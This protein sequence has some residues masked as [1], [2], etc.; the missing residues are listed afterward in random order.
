GG[1]H[2]HENRWYYLEN[3][4]ANLDSQAL[5]HPGPLPW[6]GSNTAPLGL[7][8]VTLSLF[9]VGIY[10]IREAV[11]TKSSNNPLK[12]SFPDADQPAIDIVQRYINEGLYP[13]LD[14]DIHLDPPKNPTEWL[15]R[16]GDAEAI[17]LS[18][19]LPDEVLVGAP[20]LKTIS[21]L[22]TG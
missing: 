22:G 1:D 4:L 10:E 14:F 21:F 2:N 19:A 9:H 15:D 7:I 5:D 16:I 11:M 6:N 18:W 13:E 8:L 17:M 20:N 12:V 3:N